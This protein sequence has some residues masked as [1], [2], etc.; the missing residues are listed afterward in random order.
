MAV[1]IFPPVNSY[2]WA[3]VGALSVVAAIVVPLTFNALS[4]V[5]E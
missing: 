5:A 4:N 1:P 3:I 2:T